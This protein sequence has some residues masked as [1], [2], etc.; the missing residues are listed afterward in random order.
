Q[1]ED[2]IRDFHVTG[3]QTCALPIFI[4]G[5]EYSLFQNPNIAAAKNTLFSLNF[6]K[7]NVSNIGKINIPQMSDKLPVRKLENWNFKIWSFKIG[8]ASC[9][10]IIE[11]DAA[12]M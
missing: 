8:R 9:R 12:D 1:A 7:Q 10:E 3:V 5:C 6:G 11:I 2:G 4:R